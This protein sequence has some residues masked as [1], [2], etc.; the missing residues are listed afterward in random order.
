[1]PIPAAKS[2]GFLLKRVAPILIGPLGGY[3]YY[4]FIGCVGGSCPITGN[5]WLSTGYGALLGGVF[6][7]GGAKRTGR[8]D[9]STKGEN[10]AVKPVAEEVKRKLQ[11]VIDAL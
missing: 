7:L 3:A 2:G 4:Y 1:V 8:T 10:E 11:R 9:T 6:T 5:P